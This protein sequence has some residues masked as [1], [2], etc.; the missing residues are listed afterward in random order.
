VLAIG[1]TPRNVVRSHLNRISH[2]VIN[3]ADLERSVQFYEQLTPLRVFG[4][5]DAPP[6]PF[7]ALGITEGSFDSVIMADGTTAQPGATVQLV[8]WRQPSPVGTPYST[9]FSRGLYRFC[10]LTSDVDARYERV[11]AAGYRSILP[12]KGHGIS[13]PGGVDGRSFVVRDPDGIPMQFSRRPSSWREDLPD[14]L[15]H[16]NIVSGDI[17]GTLAFL[18]DVIGLD[19]VKRLTLPAPVGPIGFGDGPPRAQYDAVFLRHRG[20]HRFAIDVVNWFLPGVSGTPY[21]EA[22][23]LGIQRIGLEVD[24]LDA[25]V[26]SLRQHGADVAAPESWDLGEA[27]VRRVAV[28]HDSEGIAYELVQQPPFDGAP[29]SPWPPEAFTDAER[30][31]FD[32]NPPDP[33]DGAG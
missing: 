3:V 8:Q 14:T 19:Y 22:T 11:L 17:A 4:R 2:I 6:Q 32:R 31:S 1:L 26:A 29:D 28:V 10:F 27:G 13:V 7:P 12:P 21:T 9:F 23:H 18:R 24:D 16:V 25:A 5:A 20:D 30:A 15:Y 33:V